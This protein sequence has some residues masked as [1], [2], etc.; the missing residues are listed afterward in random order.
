M[1]RFTKRYKYSRMNGGKKKRRKTKKNKRRK[2][3]KGG[4]TFGKQ[5]PLSSENKPDRGTKVRGRG[6]AGYTVITP[7]NQAMLIK[8]VVLLCVW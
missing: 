5:K 6:K 4:M 8:V 2:R 3:R 7:M 1:V